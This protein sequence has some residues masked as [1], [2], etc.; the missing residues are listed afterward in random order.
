MKQVAF[1]NEWEGETSKSNARGLDA[2]H[3]TSQLLIPR[4]G[5]I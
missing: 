1:L 2:A 5:G 4:T 3:S